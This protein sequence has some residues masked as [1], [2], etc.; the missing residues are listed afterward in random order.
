M[1]FTSE[2]VAIATTTPTD[3]ETTGLTSE[4]PS[5]ALF[6]NRELSWLE[7]NRRVLH[8]ALD[9]RT[10]LLE[11]V[12][13]LAIF[14]SNLDEFFMK[15]VGGLKRQLATGV[16]SQSLD[17]K[18]AGQQLSAIRAA[19]LPMLAEQA[20]VY[21]EEIRPAL[22]THG[23]HLLD[24]DEL[25]ED[26]RRF[27]DEYFRRDLFP[28]LTPLA[29]D[30]GHPFPFISNLSE[31][32]G[33]VLRHP[34]E[35]ERLFARVKIPANL[36]SWIR[37]GGPTD[38]SYRFARLQDIMINNLPALFPD[39]EVLGVMPFRVTRNADV[40]RDEE[41][42]EDLLE[43]MEEELRARRFAQRRAA[44]ARAESR[45]LALALP[46]RRA[47]ARRAGRLRAHRRARLHLACAR[48]SSSRSRSSRPSPGCRWFRARSPTTR[49]TSSA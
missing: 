26:E 15:R 40:E 27:A 5:P 36:P 45:R 24:W 39:M 47:R 1:T 12:G 31:S 49:S 32:L 18:T 29:V 6:V 4:T 19:V 21:R 17:G 34:D 43:M 14:T 22:R 3:V 37:L 46:A 35:G 16:V 41:D 33:V 25:T 48:C 13:F 44:R 2:N 9:A 7:F 10:P 38:G 23:V 30:P 11:R 20:R 8:E 28:V 42:A